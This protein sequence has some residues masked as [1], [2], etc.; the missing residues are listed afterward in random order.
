MPSTHPSKVIAQYKAVLYF[1]GGQEGRTPDGGGAVAEVDFRQA[2]IQRRKWH[3]WEIDAECGITCDVLVE[4]QLVAMRV[5]A[6]VSQAELIDYGRGEQ[7]SFAQ[8]NT[9]IRVV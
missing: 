6:V 5:D 9:A 1:P 4:I 2:A 8:G 7:V 3:T